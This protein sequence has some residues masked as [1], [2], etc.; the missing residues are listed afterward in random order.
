[1]QN[2]PTAAPSPRPEQVTEAR[3]VLRREA[4]IGCQPS[5]LRGIRRLTCELFE[6]L[7]RGP[8]RQK[9]FPSH[10]ERDALLHGDL[11]SSLLC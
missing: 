8:Q 6:R 10:V 4:A 1:M 5:E 11:R 7:Q 9:S 2:E 3:E